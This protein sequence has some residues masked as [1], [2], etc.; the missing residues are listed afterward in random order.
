MGVGSCR[1]T[2]SRTEIVQR[3]Q[4]VGMAAQQAG[5]EDRQQQHDNAQDN[6]Q[7]D[8]TPPPKKE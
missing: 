5:H 3:L 1:L 6:R 2:N 4:D 8:H 7:C